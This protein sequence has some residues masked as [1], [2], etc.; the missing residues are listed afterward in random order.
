MFSLFLSSAPS[1]RY[2]EHLYTG[3]VS[4]VGSVSLLVFLSWQVRFLG[5]AHSFHSLSTLTKIMEIS[6]IIF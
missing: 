2:Y 6:C 5:P 1:L 3:P 4:L